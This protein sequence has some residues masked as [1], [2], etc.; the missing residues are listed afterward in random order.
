[1]RGEG[2]IWVTSKEVPLTNKF[3]KWYIKVLRPF[4]KLMCI[5]TL[6][7]GYYTFVL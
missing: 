2:C 3:G 5:V 1:M 4:N 7:K 6:R